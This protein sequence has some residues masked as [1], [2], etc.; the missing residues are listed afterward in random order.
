MQRN[1]ETINCFPPF[2]LT[3]K[4]NLLFPHFRGVNKK[5]Q[6]WRSKN[7]DEQI[8]F[9]PAIRRDGL[10]KNVSEK[11]NVFPV[12]RDGLPKNVSEQIFVFPLYGA[13]VLPSILKPYLNPSIEPH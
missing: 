8:F 1:R 2:L 3:L 9:C 4:Q 11:I 10:P 12:R 7:V 13:M 5:C 6:K